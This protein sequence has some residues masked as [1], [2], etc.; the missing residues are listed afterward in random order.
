MVVTKNAS[1]CSMSNVWYEMGK[2]CRGYICSHQRV[3][4]EFIV[5]QGYGRHSKQ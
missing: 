4:M 1:V 5:R 2:F 3:L